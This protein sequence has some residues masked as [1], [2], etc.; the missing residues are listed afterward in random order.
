MR[1]ED[2]QLR[3][4]YVLGQVAAISSNPCM[5]IKYYC[6]AWKRCCPFDRTHHTALFVKT[7]PSGLLPNKRQS[8]AN[9]SHICGG[10]EGSNH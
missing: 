8:Y 7:S 1:T 5:S 2:N 9:V 6:I 10:P 3:I 4:N